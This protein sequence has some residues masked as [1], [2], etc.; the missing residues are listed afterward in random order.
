MFKIGSNFSFR[1]HAADIGRVAYLSLCA[2]ISAAV[3]LEML[4]PGVA[5][6]IIS[7]QR[8]VSAAV[9]AGALALLASDQPVPA[10]WRMALYI[11]TALVLTV[12]A[13]SVGTAYFGSMVPAGAVSF[14]VALPFLAYA[15]TH[16]K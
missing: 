8:L 2:I 11:A 3:M 10:N 5:G 15:D 14:G 12:L 13:F 9:I 1:A 16:K 7:P 4:A 6:N